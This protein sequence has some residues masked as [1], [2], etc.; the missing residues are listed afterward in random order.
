MPRPAYT[1]VPAKTYGT[2]ANAVGALTR[3]CAKF[4]ID[5]SMRYVVAADGGRFFPVI[6]PTEA[7]V[8]Q[9]IILAHHGILMVR[10]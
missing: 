6:L 10:T 5:D 7:Q 2:V 3:A 8:Q 4:G 9:G 1:E